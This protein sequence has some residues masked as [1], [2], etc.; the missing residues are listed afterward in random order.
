MSVPEASL[1][2]YGIQTE[3]SH[4]RVHVCPVVKR[5]YVY[6]TITGVEAIESGKFPKVA[7]YQTDHEGPTAEGY[8]V[9]PFAIRKCVGLV[10]SERAWQK[11]RFSRDDALSVKGDKA[12]RLVLAMLREGLL[13]LPRVAREVK[14]RDL[15]IQG[16]DIVVPAQV[17][18]GED[19]RIQVKCDYDGGENQLG[20]TG[21]LFM[22][23]SEYNP[24]HHL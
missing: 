6:P 22:Q 16:M 2:K 24:F 4:I 20:G 10:F 15:Q 21:N 19:I 9:P 8:L 12:T 3:D 5:V 14:D 1:I 11:F 17:V 23:E 7:G 18:M 13:P